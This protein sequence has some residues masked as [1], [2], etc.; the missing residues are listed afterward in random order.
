[1]KALILAAGMG[2]R[3]KP[4]TDM[5]PK[6][7]VAVNGQPILF[8]QIENLVTHGIKD[9]TVVV[10]YKADLIIEALEMRYPFVNVITN[11]R[12]RET[13]N[14][15]SAYLAKKDFYNSE[16]ILMNADVFYDC[17]VIQ[18]LMK[19]KY[20]NAIVVDANKYNEENMKVRCIDDRIVEIGKN[21]CKTNSFGLSIDVYKFSTTASFRLF[22]KITEYVTRRNETNLWTEVAINDI[23][24]IEDFRICPLVGR[25]IEIDDFDDLNRAERIFRC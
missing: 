25:W 5:K 1:M 4:I 15:F 24:A 20:V 7:M 2:T 21:I 16:F 23:L 3:L 10:G 22:D 12:Y 13:N 18:E 6:A 9:I 8:K 17:T 19:S 11:S 14:M